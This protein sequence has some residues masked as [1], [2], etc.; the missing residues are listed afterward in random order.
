MAVYQPVQKYFNIPITHATE[1][2]WATALQKDLVLILAKVLASDT[3]FHVS[4]FQF[5]HLETRGVRN[6]CFV[7]MP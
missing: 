5:L 7:K 4:D 2:T 3:L 1:T 6:T